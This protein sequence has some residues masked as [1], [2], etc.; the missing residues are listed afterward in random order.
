MPSSD[1]DVY[2]EAAPAP[3]DP[4]IP[5]F[6]EW[7]LLKSKTDQLT[8]EQNKLRDRVVK[9]VEER[10][11]T[12]HKGSQ[13]LDLPFPITAGDTSYM[14]IKRERRVTVVPDA[15]AAETILRAK[16]EHIFHRAFPPVPMLDQNE[17]Y[18]LLQ[19]GIL[20]EDDMD[21]IFIQRESFAFRG[22]AA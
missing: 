10:G 11:Y 4:I 5:V 18:V 19:E 13:Y 17:L 3:M 15:T 12:D 7:A 16:G 20:T 6:R 14:R 2:E 22:L 1:L 8:A 9:A 21:A